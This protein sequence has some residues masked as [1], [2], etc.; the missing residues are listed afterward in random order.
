MCEVFP[1][2]A[3][4]TIKEGG[5][6]WS[7]AQVGVLQLAGA[8]FLLIGNLVLLPLLRTVFASSLSMQRFVI[9]ALA[10]PGFSLFPAVSACCAGNST[11]ATL[12]LLPIFFLRITS[13]GLIFT[14][15]FQ[16]INSM[17]R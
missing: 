4:T 8:V 12:V 17:V 5:L 6:A 2:W 11:S 14:L 3:I 9:L 13:T 16:F 10:I 1:L 7:P 15:T